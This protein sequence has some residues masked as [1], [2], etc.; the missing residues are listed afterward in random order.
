MP[1]SLLSDFEKAVKDSA[2]FRGKYKH[3]VIRVRAELAETIALTRTNINESRL[4]MEEADVV[5]ARR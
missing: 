3:A 5:M 1:R 2:E 4:L